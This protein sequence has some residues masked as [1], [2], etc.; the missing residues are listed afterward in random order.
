[1]VLLNRAL[2]PARPWRENIEAR[3]MELPTG[4]QDHFP[5]LL[6]G[7]LEI[8]HEPGG[9]QVRHL[10]VD[11]AALGRS[12]LVVYTGQSHFSAGSNWRMIRRRLESDPEDDSLFRWDPRCRQRDG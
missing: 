6:G 5:A 8:R 1:M 9:E 12:L 4:C 2:N 7:V 10:A 3:L 11:L